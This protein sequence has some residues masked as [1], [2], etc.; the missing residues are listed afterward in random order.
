MK[1][2]FFFVA[3]L[4]ASTAQAQEYGQADPVKTAEM[5]AQRCAKIS[6]EQS[7]IRRRLTGYSQPYD[8]RKMQEKQKI[9]QADYAKFCTPKAAP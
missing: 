3:I 9:L 8:I 2:I 5:A 6:K 1:L 7:L 4:L